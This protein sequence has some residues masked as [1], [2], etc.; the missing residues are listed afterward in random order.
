M[1]KIDITKIDGYEAMSAE[2]KVAAL[3]ASEVAEDFTGHVK[4]D[5]YDKTASELAKVKKDL[6]DK[7]TEEER[8]TA[9][10][11]EKL[12]KL[13]EENEKLHKDSKIA[14]YTSHYLSLGYEATLAEETAKATVENDMDKVLANQKIH[15]ENVKKQAVVDAQTKTPEPPKA[16]GKPNEVTRETL[17]KMSA[18][19]R[20]QYSVQNPEKY[21]E[22][23]GGK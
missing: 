22:I 20:Y 2:D 14:K 8:R 12:V 5:V 7:L 19:E 4:K 9:E 16:G 3:E 18:S 23:Y 15:I 17:S 10:E 1:A 6:K 13:Q 11:Q 21:K